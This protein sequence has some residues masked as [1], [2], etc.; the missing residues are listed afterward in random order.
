[1]GSEQSHS[2]DAIWPV[3]LLLA[4]RDEHDVA[5]GIVSVVDRCETPPTIMASDLDHVRA[6]S[7]TMLHVLN[8]L[9]Y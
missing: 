3:S 8:H 4:R 5:M 9:T 7:L 2:H 6:W 1:M